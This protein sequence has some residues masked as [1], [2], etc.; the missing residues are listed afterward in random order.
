MS[1]D[2][3]IR[4]GAVVAAVAILAAPYRQQAASWLAQAWTAATPYRGLAARIAAASLLL[5]AA[6]GRLPSLPALPQSSP[7]V[8]ATPT[9]E[10][11]KAV[12]GVEAAMAGVGSGDRATWREAWRKAAIV[13]EADRSSG[14]AQAFPKT[15]ALRSY[16]TLVLDIAWRRIGGHKPGTVD[17][18]RTATEAAYAA[19]VGDA[20]VPVTPEVREQ[21]AA[22]ADGMI[23]AAR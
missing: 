3:L 22:L 19:V 23:W 13:V 14:E 1:T 2:D 10:V 20:D 16:T 6:W 12:A 8:V 9:A 21:F 4:A 5:V 15:A 11:L 18:L 17:G 7:V